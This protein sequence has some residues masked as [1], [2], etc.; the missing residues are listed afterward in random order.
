MSLRFY[1]AALALAGGLHIPITAWAADQ[2]SAQ[3]ACT[4]LLKRVAVR[5]HKSFETTRAF[6]DCDITT[7]DDPKWHVIGL[8]SPRKCEG[9]W[10][11]SNLAGWFAV[12]R[13]TGH[14]RYWDMGEGAVGAEIEE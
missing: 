7:W 10:E 11:C 12:S 2:V 6:Y 14:V 3:E 4:L 1:L 9:W 8:R 5:D 13:E